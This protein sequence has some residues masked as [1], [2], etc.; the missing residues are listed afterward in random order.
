MM[1][2]VETLSNLQLVIQVYWG[3]MIILTLTTDIL[4]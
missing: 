3:L 4:I 1:Y 2:A